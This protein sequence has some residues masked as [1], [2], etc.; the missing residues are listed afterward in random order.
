MR[1]ALLVLLVVAVVAIGASGDTPK[2]V[3]KTTKLSLN[4][5]AISCKTG[6]R[7]LVNTKT[8]GTYVVVTCE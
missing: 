6:N 8:D 5:V 2:P 7:P 1:K 4:D 3:Y